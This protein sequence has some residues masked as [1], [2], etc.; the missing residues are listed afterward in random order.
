MCQV[1]GTAGERVGTTFTTSGL[2]Q[3]LGTQPSPVP[4]SL[5]FPE[6]L[7]DTLLVRSARP[8][9]QEAA[10]TQA[11]ILRLTLNYVNIFSP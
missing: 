11:F 9:S 10:F 6:Q 1:L 3:P 7:P 4:F 5:M 2:L 8:L